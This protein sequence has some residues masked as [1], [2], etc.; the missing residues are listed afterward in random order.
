[1]AKKLANEGFNICI[2]SRT[3][4]KINEKLDEIRKECRS[5]DESFKTLA[6]VADFSKL[7]TIKDYQTAI[8]D[9]LKDVDVGVLVLC[10]GYVFFGPYKD[11]TGDEVERHITTNILHVAY[12]TKV[13]VNQLVQRFDSKGKKSALVVISSIL[14]SRQMSGVMS[15]CASKVFATYFAMGLNPELR[16]KVDVI[17]YEPGGIATKMMGMSEPSG[18]YIA[19]EEAANQPFRDIGMLQ[20]TRGVFIH[21]IIAWFMSLPPLGLLQRASLYG[22]TQEFNKA[23]A[24]QAERA[25]AKAT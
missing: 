5:G 11:L 19:P 4:S 2:I 7:L 25:K 12:T 14:S 16:N 9:K 13:L 18:P 24:E 22:T 23:R 15:Y 20:M 10:A 8:G 17:A 3:E 1:M 6:V 21:E